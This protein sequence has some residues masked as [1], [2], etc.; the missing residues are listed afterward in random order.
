MFQVIAVNRILIILLSLLTVVS[1][2][3]AVSAEE[4]LIHLKSGKFAEEINITKTYPGA[5]GDVQVKNISEDTLKIDIGNFVY[6]FAP[7]GATTSYRGGAPPRK[8][9]IE[10]LLSRVSIVDEYGSPTSLLFDNV[11]IQC[12]RPIYKVYVCNLLQ[13]SNSRGYGDYTVTIQGGDY[14]IGWCNNYCINEISLNG[15]SIYSDLYPNWY[16][17]VSLTGNDT[18]SAKISNTGN[19]YW[20]A[21]INLAIISFDTPL[22]VSG[23]LNYPNAEK[24]FDIS[25]ITYPVTIKVVNGLTGELLSGVQVKMKDGLFSTVV[26]GVSTVNLPRGERTYTFSKGGYWDVDKTIT[27][28]ETSQNLTVELFPSDSIFEVSQSPE[29]IAT[30]PS[31]IADVTL[32]IDPIEDG[33]G[34]KLY[35]TNVDVIKVE[36]NG[37]VIPKS[38]DGSYIIGDILDSTDVKITFAVPDTIGERQFIARFTASDI[39]GNQYVIQKAVYYT[40]QEL[41]FIIQ[42]PASWEVGTN[43]LTIIEQA[44]EDYLVLVVLRDLNG[45]ELWS[46]SAAFT[47]YDSQTFNVQ[48]PAPGRYVLEITAKGGAVTTYIPMTIVEPIKLLTPEVEGS[49]GSIATVQL[50]IKN[51]GSDVKY[52]DAVVTGSIFTDNNTPKTTFSIAP[53]ETKTVDLN[54]QIPDNLEFDS[55]DLQ[56]QVFEKD[57]SEPLFSDKVVLKITEGSF[58]P[59]GIG[60]DNNNLLLIGAVIAILLLGIGAYFRVRT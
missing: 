46:Q 39:R 12:G 51:P 57:D 5:I 19:M 59:F 17:L 20:Y 16:S 47:A 11:D 15:R 34:T 32:S 38:N 33:Y 3:S 36:K 55:Y 10:D 8:L 25:P 49:K 35:I 28:G 4:V 54:F 48:I 6:L 45:T 58:L 30:Y 14:I 44:G 27:V 56:V 1:M 18:L 37:I 23:R 22:E 24:V 7:I 53:G 13:T 40:V 43:S 29:Q 41:P 60:G 42:K 21:K 31:S 9:V 50:E 2:S 52:Y 26:N